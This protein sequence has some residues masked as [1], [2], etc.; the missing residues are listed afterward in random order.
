MSFS[1]SEILPARP[2]CDIGI[3]T[4]K[5]PRRTALKT[6]RSCSVFNTSVEAAVIR[7]VDRRFD[8][9]P[10]L[11]DRSVGMKTPERESWLWQAETY[12]SVMRR[13]V[14]AVRQITSVEK[15]G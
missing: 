14:A 3:R 11:V 5:S 7:G 12:Q 4:V 2:T 9:R 6:A 1:V 15:T 10:L 8:L 13:T